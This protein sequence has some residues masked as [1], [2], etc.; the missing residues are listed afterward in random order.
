MT[1]DWIRFPV[2]ETISSGLDSY[3]IDRG[4][5]HSLSENRTRA[6]SFPQLK[7]TPVGAGRTIG[8]GERMRIKDRYELADELKE[9]YKAAAGRVERSRI[10]DA[11]RLAT[12]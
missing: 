12:G 11:F 7:I 2:E 3:A 5:T 9:H 8:V 1:K 6:P 4:G 10:L